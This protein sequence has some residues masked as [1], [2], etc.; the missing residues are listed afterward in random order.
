ML[1]HVIVNNFWY[2]FHQIATLFQNK[3]YKILIPFHPMDW[4]HLWTIP[5]KIFFDTTITTLILTT[6]TLIVVRLRLNWLLL[7]II[8]FT[9]PQCQVERSKSFSNGC[10]ERAL[11]ANLVFIDRFDD[12]LWDTHRS[13]GVPHWSY[14][15]WIPNNRGFGSSKNPRDVSKY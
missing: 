14:V 10:H 13:I 12:G 15:N 1:P 9:F 2:F 4:R 8:G 11:Q 3:A 7:M 5:L 6:A